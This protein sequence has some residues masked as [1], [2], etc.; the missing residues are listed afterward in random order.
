[1]KLKRTILWMLAVA[2]VL[3]A[4]LVGTL[5]LLHDHGKMERMASES[6]ESASALQ[7]ANLNGFFDQRVTNMRITAQLPMM[8]QYLRDGAGDVQALHDILANRVSHQA[9]LRGIVVTD[10][11]GKVAAASDEKLAGFQT[12]DLAALGFLQPGEVLQTNVFLDAYFQPGTKACALILAM[13]DGNERLGYMIEVI[14][15]ENISALIGQSDFSASGVLCLQDG[16]GATISATDSKVQRDLMDSESDFHHKWADVD[17]GLHP[18]GILH[19]K[20]DGQQMA[21]H[22]AKVDHSDWVLLSAISMAELTQPARQSL[23]MCLLAMAVIVT[24][25]V[26]ANMWLVKRFTNPIQNMVDGISDM[27][28]QLALKHLPVSR[29]RD[30]GSIAESFNQLVDRVEQKNADLERSEMRYRA[31][32]QQ[33]SNL[34]FEINLTAD[35]IDCGELPWTPKGFTPTG[36]YSVMLERIAQSV[37]CEEDRQAFC[38]T[39]QRER[40]LQAFQQGARQVYLEYLGYDQ[41][42]RIWMACTVLPLSERR[43]EGELAVGYVQNIDDRKHRDLELQQQ[44]QLDGLTHLCNRR[45]TQSQIDNYL[46][47]DSARRLH[48][49]LIIDVD[50]FKTIN[51]QLGHL[52]G[53]AVLRDV[54]NKLRSL[55]SPADILGRVGG[56]EFVVFLADCPDEACIARRAEEVLA[57]FRRSFA[58]PGGTYQVSCSVGAA[59]SPRDGAS[60]LALFR[61]ADL[62]L[63]AA[64]DQGKDRYCLYDAASDLSKRLETQPAFLRQH[65]DIEPV[66]AQQLKQSLVEYIFSTLYDSDDLDRALMLILELLG[67]YFDVSRVYIFEDDDETGTR[68]SNTYEWCNEGIPPEQANLQH[69]SYEACGD[70][71]GYFDS[72]GILYFDDVEELPE[73]LRDFLRRQGIRSMLQCAIYQDGVFK[74]FVG[75]DDCRKVHLATPEEIHLLMLVAQIISTFLLKHKAQLALEK[76]HRM[77]QSVMDHLNTWNYV[78]DMDSYEL[79]FVNRKTLELA[80]QTKLGQPC[81]AAFQGRQQPCLNC[82]LQGLKR[83]GQPYTVEFH[84]QNLGVWTLATADQMEWVDGKQVCILCC[85]D[86]TRFKKS[87]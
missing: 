23:L 17:L 56:D 9:F 20:V 13:E 24:A 38:T 78:V 51:D 64:K 59:L 7:M 48:A 68:T 16:V 44:A 31:V 65:D 69:V 41:G 21:V 42:R 10:E 57:L 29:D 63:Y 83:T 61:R 67:R 75:F 80:P 84:N 82:P 35:T 66:K 45:T 3:P 39:F 76:S 50:N 15:L 85:S 34:V 2:A 81:Y 86:I 18:S 30:L 37:V 77:T 55:F 33:T 53:D 62:A 54:A 26:L 70:Y 47:A 1:M 5:Q 28:G 49:L 36:A 73:A 52:L 58:G 79:L 74:G 43:G 71:R 40:L 19:A 72:D 46:A 6:L 12:T 32:L 4:L 60:Y 25:M 27:Q 11:A 8:E 22:Y 14:G 87:E